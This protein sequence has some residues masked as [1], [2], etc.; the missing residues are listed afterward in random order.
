MTSQK[1][2]FITI[3]HPANSLQYHTPLQYFHSKQRTRIIVNVSA[4]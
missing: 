1:V 2:V 4:A 3:P